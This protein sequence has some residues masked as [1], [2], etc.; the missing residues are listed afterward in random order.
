VIAPA[1]ASPGHLIDNPLQP[2]DI[3]IRHTPV[4]PASHPARRH[5]Q[6]SS[7]SLVSQIHLVQELNMR[8]PVRRPIPIPRSHQSRPS[9]HSPRP[10]LQLRHRDPPT[11]APTLRHQL[12]R[13][14]RLTNRLE[15]SVQPLC[16]FAS[17]KPIPLG[18]PALPTNSPRHA[19]GPEPDR[20]GH[21][22]H[23]HCDLRFLR[24]LRHVSKRSEFSTPNTSSAHTVETPRFGNEAPLLP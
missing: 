23:R 14:Q 3:Q 20:L 18:Q 6:P 10:P 22:R 19:V 5:P 11:T 12:P 13:I 15:T 1:R 21:L 17:E 7:Q 8:T 2:S 24:L 9:R 16:R 4:T